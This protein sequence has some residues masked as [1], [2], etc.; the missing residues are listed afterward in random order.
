MN[1]PAGVSPRFFGGLAALNRG[2]TPNAIYFRPKSSE[3]FGDSR[4]FLAGKRALAAPVASAIPLKVDG[5]GLT[6]AG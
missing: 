1:Q 2:L 3:R 5:I 4:R 6:P